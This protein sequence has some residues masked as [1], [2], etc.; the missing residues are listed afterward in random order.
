[1]WRRL[2][3]RAHDP[4]SAAIVPRSRGTSFKSLCPKV[5]PEIMPSRS[6]HKGALQIEP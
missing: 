3:R 4:E 5:P 1:M 6:L 2:P